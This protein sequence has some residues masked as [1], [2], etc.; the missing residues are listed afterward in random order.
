MKGCIMKSKMILGIAILNLALI[1]ACCP[2]ANR[3]SEERDLK[4]TIAALETQTAQ[5]PSMPEESPP[6]KPSPTPT[7]I[8]VTKTPSPT[9]ATEAQSW[10]VIPIGAFETDYY[11]YSINEGLNAAPSGW[12]WLVVE[13]AIQNN[14]PEAG[15][16]PGLSSRSR[17]SLSR[18]LVKSDAG[19]EYRAE[20]AI[21]TNLHLAAACLP[22]GMRQY[23]PI[24][25]KVPENQEGFKLILPSGT[26][27]DLERD[28]R[29]TAFPGEPSGDFEIVGSGQPLIVA[30]LVELTVDKAERL[31]PDT[32][33]VL[34]LLLLPDTDE[35]SV[36]LTAKNLSGYNLQPRSLQFTIIGDDGL[37]RLPWSSQHGRCQDA[38]G[39]KPFDA[40]N[41][42]PIPP[43]HASESLPICFEVA[44]IANNFKLIVTQQPPGKP[45]FLGVFDLR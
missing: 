21:S 11:A 15:T 34:Y 3:T 33:S 36:F 18:A 16:Y 32:E 19:Y 45:E 14:G 24:A 10:E 1:S 22:P 20:P 30:N 4:A 28:I 42:K 12:K 25:F 44:K 43:G 7:S 29:P 27:S 39:V 13:L 2:L 31:E 40:Y 23:W 35:L 8:P 17:L 5:Q 6:P 37:A 9:P 38:R 26:T 41:A